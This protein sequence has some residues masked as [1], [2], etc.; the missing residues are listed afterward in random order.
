MHLLIIFPLVYNCLKI[1]QTSEI[2]EE[3]GIF[4]GE[5]EEKCCFWAR[6]VLFL[7]PA[8]F[9]TLPVIQ[10]GLLFVYYRTAHQWAVILFPPTPKKNKNKKQEHVVEQEL[11]DLPQKVEKLSQNPENQALLAEAEQES[12]KSCE[13]QQEN[14]QEKKQ[15]NG[16]NHVT[17]EI[18]N[19]S[20]RLNQIGPQNSQS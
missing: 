2:F 10:L 3:N 11:Q 12:T 8:I 4:L 14:E 18:N 19:C 16:S 9:V 6:I 17:I 15:E 20:N 5:E 13:N 7:L 1:V